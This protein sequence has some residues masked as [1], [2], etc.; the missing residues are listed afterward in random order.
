MCLNVL[1]RSSWYKYQYEVLCKYD[2]LLFIAKKVVA[3]ATCTCT[4]GTCSAVSRDSG[5]VPAERYL[6]LYVLHNR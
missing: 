5:Q 6:Y 2:C 4:T 3:F 1:C